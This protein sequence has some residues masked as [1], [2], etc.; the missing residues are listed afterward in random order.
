MNIEG[1][2]GLIVDDALYIVMPSI[3]VSNGTGCY[4]ICKYPCPH[5]RK[6]I[7]CGDPEDD[8]DHILILDS[9]QAIA[10]Y[11]ALRLEST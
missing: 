4:F 6:L 3:L 2:K 1:M 5:Q 7:Y 11:V 10:A 9:P 8:A